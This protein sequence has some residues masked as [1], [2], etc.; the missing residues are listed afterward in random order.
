MRRG[1]TIGGDGIF[2]GGDVRLQPTAKGDIVVAGGKVDLGRSID[3]N[4]TIASPSI[5]LHPGTRIGGDL[6]YRSGTELTVPDGVSISGRVIRKDWPEASEGSGLIA[7][8]AG[9][10]GFL[11]ALALLAFGALIIL[12]SLPG[13][14]AAELDIQPLRALGLGFAIAL[15]VPAASILLM[16]MVIGIPLALFALGV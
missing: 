16:I 8:L 11:A 14:A 10:I 3:G 9:A 1:T 5:V 4:V 12:G 7:G 13:R 2:A 6:T 15:A